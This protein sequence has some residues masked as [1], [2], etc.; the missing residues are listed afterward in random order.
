M[1]ATRALAPSTVSLTALWFGLFGAAAAWSV[2][3][4]VNYALLAHACYPSWYPLAAPTTPAAWPLSVVV[5]IV[6]LLVGTAAV[7]TALQAWRRARAQHGREVSEERKRFMASS[8]VIVSSILLAN[9]VMNTIV[10]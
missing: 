1:T 3:E 2:Q 5:S 7:L 9:I 8:G 10:L 6:A 4:L